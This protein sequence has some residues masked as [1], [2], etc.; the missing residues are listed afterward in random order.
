MIN[1]A[2]L[3]KKRRLGVFNYNEIPYTPDPEPGNPLWLV[4]IIFGCCLMLL[5]LISSCHAKNAPVTA[6]W[7]GTTGDHCDPWK[8]TRTSN[9]ERFNENAMTAASWAF[10]LG[11]MVKVTSLKTG[12]FIVVRINDRGP[13][14][15]LYRKGRIIDLTRGA[16]KRIANLRDGVI[17]IKVEVIL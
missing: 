10:P 1:N 14:K 7:Y 3:R 2:E 9:G 6:S 16:F 4:G 13:S 17:K 8:H 5:L 12:Q 11:S 15:H